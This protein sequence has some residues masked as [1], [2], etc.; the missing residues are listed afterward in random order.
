M[1]RSCWIHRQGLECAGGGDPFYLKQMRLPI[2]IRRFGTNPRPKSR[3]ERRLP[4]T[5]CPVAP[6]KRSFVR[7]HN[8]FDSIPFRN[9][10]T[11]LSCLGSQK[12]SAPCETGRGKAENEAENY[13]VNAL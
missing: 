6:G 7:P 13:S 4:A 3:P 5:Q 1:S 2:R 8:F 11:M 10:E 12:K 9:Q